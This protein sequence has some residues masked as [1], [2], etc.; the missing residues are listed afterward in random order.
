MAKTLD[1]NAESVVEAGRA[2][3]EKTLSN[4]K[5]Q[6]QKVN[7]TAK[8]NLEEMTKFQND[9]INASFEA[10]TIFAKGMEELT[11]NFM[12]FTQKAIIANSDAMKTLS[13]VK[14]P[15]EFADVSKN[16]VQGKIEELV[17]DSVNLSENLTKV[18][19]D[20]HRPFQQ[21]WKISTDKAFKNFV[22]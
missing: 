4:Q 2:V 20:T 15:S 17:K 16:M 22:A 7:E 12:N 11:R 10:Q 19:N 18:A 21:F 6:A 5:E 9:V 3:V 1:I 13:E 14:T 8:K